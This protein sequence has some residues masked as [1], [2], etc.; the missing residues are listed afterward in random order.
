MVKKIKCIV[1]HSIFLIIIYYFWHIQ[2]INTMRNLLLLLLCLP[3][4]GFGQDDCGDK[5]IYKGNYKKKY[6]SKNAYKIYSKKLKTWQECSGEFI[7]VSDSKNNL[8]IDE[9]DLTSETSIKEYLDEN[10]VEYIEGIWETSGLGTNYKLFIRKDA[11]LYKAYVIGKQS[12]NVGFKANLETTDSADV[13]T[14]NWLTQ[15]KNNIKTVGTVKNN[16][17]IEFP[18]NNI[19]N[20]LYRVYPKFDKNLQ[21]S[22]T[23]PQQNEI[24]PTKEEAMLEVKKLKEL[25]D[26]GIIT[27]EEFDKRATELK[28]VILGN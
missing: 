20:I 8:I 16:S 14:I 11:D 5:P 3:M 7:V 18:L 19:K 4:I 15:N 27:Q 13:L 12:I 2:I 22:I 10:G 21:T 6:K 17:I 28:K 9:L 23:A 24:K 1:S 25:L 26:L